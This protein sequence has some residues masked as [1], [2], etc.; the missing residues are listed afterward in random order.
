M[1]MQT[2]IRWVRTRATLTQLPARYAVLI[3]VFVAFAFHATAY[4]V[5]EKPL[6]P[7]L[8]W[9]D[10]LWVTYISFTTIGYGD[11]Y[12]TTPW[13]RLVTVATTLV[14]IGGLA[15][16]AGEVIDFF[17]TRGERRRRGM[18][19]LSHLHDHVLVI[20]WP[21]EA[22]VRAAVEKVR[23]D[24][25]MR[26]ATI[27]IVSN[28]IDELPP[29]MAGDV[30]FSKGSP[31]DLSTL[32]KANA[33][34]AQSA[35]I[36][37]RQPGE[38]ETDTLTAA[39]IA[40]VKSL[41]PKATTIAEIVDLRHHPLFITAGCD[42]I[43]PT[44]QIGHNLLSLETGNRGV[45]SFIEEMTDPTK[46]SSLTSEPTTL[47]GYDFRDAAV[48]LRRMPE[49]I[50]LLGIVRDKTSL[51]NPAQGCTIEPGDNLIFLAADFD[52]WAAIE[53]KVRA[54]LDRAPAQ[55]T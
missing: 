13:S 4:Y 7:E 27:V 31:S 28:D 41:N 53:G 45:A 49:R 34:S 43:V 21:G 48:A 44:A 40:Q 10:A 26:R 8:T 52:S 1:V 33:A 23:S 37:A 55:E 16:I 50:I 25:N 5:N 12:A 20:N 42:S 2:L 11:L 14:G 36:L 22:A 18:L 17:A 9:E 47:G 38:G 32:I 54:M 6:Q 15:V 39:A 3:V 19:E 46:G 29:D 35:L 30:Y 24:P 51:V